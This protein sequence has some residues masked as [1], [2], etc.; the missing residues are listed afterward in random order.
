[1]DNILTVLFGN[2]EALEDKDMPD[3]PDWP[4]VLYKI[5]EDNI[6]RG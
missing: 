1:M 4:Y 3:H 6:D 2:I 5:S